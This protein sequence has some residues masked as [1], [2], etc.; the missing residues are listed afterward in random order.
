MKNAWR[1]YVDTG[2][3]FTDCLAL[4]PEGGL[5]RAKVLS[6]SSLRGVVTERIDGRTLRVKEDWGA[7]P[8]L[9]AGFEF[10]V[11][12]GGSR[13]A[14]CKLVVES[15]DRAGSRLRFE[16][17]LPASVDTGTRFEVC[18][19]EEAPLLAARLVTG[20]P[21]GRPLPPLSLR[22]ATTRGTNA[23]LERRG[24]RVALFITR[25][26]RDLLE[27]GTQ[28]RP[29]LFAL[30]IE[31]PQALYHAVVE[32]PE[33]LAAD[34]SVLEPLDT[35]AV[36]ARAEAVLDDG[37]RVAAV[38]LLHA[39]RNPVH[40]ER[41]ARLLREAG[42]D[43]VTTSSGVAPRIKVL[44]RAQTAVADA[45]LSPVVDGYVERV[46]RGLSGGTLHLM[47]SAGGL[48]RPEEFRAKD[49]LLS[50]PA[51]G[52]MGAA[53][54]GLLSGFSRVIAFDMGGTSTDV[55]RFDQVPEY[56]WEHS[57]GDARLMAPALHVESVAAGGGSVCALGPEGLSVGPESAGASPGPACYGAGGPLT[58]TDV[59]LLLG[60]VSPA[61]FAL[62]VDPGAARARLDELLALLRRRGGEEAAPEPLL[63]GLLRV[64]DERMAGA[65]RQVSLRRG[66]DPAEHTLVA[67]GGAGPQHGCAVA[68][69][70]GIGTVLVPADAGLLSALGLE[71]AVL[72][73]FAER[74]LLLSLVE[75]AGRLDGWL[76]ELEHEATRRLRAE[77]LAAEEVSIRRRL[78]R[79]RYQGQ[80]SA[81]EVE[82]QSAASL[83]QRFEESYRRLYGHLPAG[84]EVEVV[85]LSAL[86]SSPMTE[87]RAAAA[88][89]STPVQPPETLRLWVGGAWVEAGTYQRAELP[90]GGCFAGPAL[91]AESHSV[92]FVPPGWSL[93]VDGAGALVLTS[94][95]EGGDE[96]R[97]GAAPRSGPSVG[98]R[99][100]AVEDELFTN[101]F[102]AVVEEMGERLRST[103]LSV[104][105]RERL[106]FSCAL[107][108]A[109]GR[110]VANAPH[111]PVHLGALGLCVR[112]V[113]R[114]LP[115]GPGDVA[116]TNHP[117][118][119]GSHLPDVTVIAAVHDGSGERVGYLANRAHHAEIGG[120]RPGSMPPLARCLADE[121]VVIPPLYLFRGGE[122]RWGGVEELLRGGRFPSRAPSDNLADLGAQVAAVLRGVELV[123]GLACQHG[124]GT[125]R[126]H[127]EALGARAARR[128]GE[129]LA[130]LGDG[131]YR[132]AERL[133]DGSPLRVR[134]TVSGAS[135]RFDFTGS[136]GVHPGNLNA[137][138]AIVRSVVLYVLRLLVDE[139]IPLNEGLLEPVSLLIPEGILSPPFPADPT[140]CPAVV[141]GN[142]ET[143]QRLADTLLKALELAACS[144]GTMNNL[145][146]GN[147]R[148]GY[149]ETIGGGS[150]AGAGFHGAS[151]VQ[152]HMT[153]TRITDP[154]VLEHRYPVRVAR[155][156]LRPGSGGRGRWRGGDGLVREL[157]FLEPVELSVL[158]QHR[159]VAPYGAGGGGPGKPGRQRLVRPSGKVIQLASSDSFDAQPGD[160]LIVETPGGGGWGE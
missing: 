104:N 149:Y 17:P 143:S 52:V 157:E 12:A 114:A 37:V 39:Y 119:G 141:G 64:A 50:G 56:R 34:G 131:E 109:G 74:Q 107:L 103:A 139:P 71:H 93:R 99:V 48:V 88:P 15:F 78:A 33:R 96:D 92:T 118:F 9:P 41:L 11:L 73:R 130:R 150:G 5:H 128:A 134:I 123:E 83:R 133:D 46:G 72:E 8:D 156:S 13:P 68:A 26:F 151:G 85:A 7:C 28:Q 25:G 70:L 67:F 84:P 19:P 160:R 126:R 121:G 43:R 145:L 16:S 127:M 105:V 18:S 57:V 137:T 86:A 106:D 77:G 29:D 135:A 1:V 158:T 59:N 111:I 60:R 23:L 91:V 122:P 136:A 138:P 82:Y 62:P 155:F 65:I 49:S 51:G 112:E 100:T 21:A 55:A 116:V 101:R 108:D 148:F 45:Y 14:G 113:V 152:V 95:R 76:R 42:F 87:A 102:R 58:L 132:A 110:L 117:A 144:Q 75:C 20:T 30:N 2:G 89:D 81:L 142:V 3:T 24:A 47:T 66:H 97:K 4:D 79:L 61:D 53:R 154:E 120:T 159:V 94:S 129:A 44:E 32:V 80:E 125:V 115:L 38:A 147:Q 153:N 140:R 31:R 6:T 10:R 90:P 35:K 36:R 146:F 22:L 27:I 40:E 63:E 69:E 54:A 98:A 124:T